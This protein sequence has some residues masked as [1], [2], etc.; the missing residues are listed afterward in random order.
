MGSFQRIGDKNLIGDKEAPHKSREVVKARYTPL[1]AEL[2]P[3]KLQPAH[4]NSKAAI[5][6]QRRTPANKR[7]FTPARVP[8]RA[9]VSWRSF[10]LPDAKVQDSPSK[11]SPFPASARL[12]R[13]TTLNQ[14][15]QKNRRKRFRRMTW[16]TASFLDQQQIVLSGS[17]IVL[18]WKA[19]II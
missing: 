2:L 7:A 14:T 12:L 15:A 16:F 8:Y 9:V 19:D 3:R 18:R 1:R 5:P 6:S 11:S 10:Q 4:Q 17:R 13:K